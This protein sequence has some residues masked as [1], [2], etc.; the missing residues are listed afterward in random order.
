MVTGGGLALPKPLVDDKEKLWFKRYETCALAN[1]WNDQKKLLRLPML[2]KGR[3][4]AIYD[5][6]T[7]QG[8][9]PDTYEHLKAAILTH[10]CPDTE[11]RVVACECLS[12]RCLRA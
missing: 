4:W 9:G 1:G 2:L 5:S 8:Y 12:K 6:L 3:A 11:D 10:L 7:G